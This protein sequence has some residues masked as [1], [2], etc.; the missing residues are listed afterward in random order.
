MAELL[1]ASLEMGPVSLN[2]RD[3]APL[4]DFYQTVIG[5][6]VLK[7]DGTSVSFGHSGK[8]IVNLHQT[9]KLQ[10]A[11]RGSAGLYHLAIRFSARGD[12]ARA[13]QRV[14]TQTSS[15]YTGSGD[16][17]VSEAFYLADPE[18]NGIELYY[19]R[20]PSKWTWKDGMVQME[21]LY[22]N[23]DQY[24]AKNAAARPDQTDSFGQ[25]EEQGTVQM[26]HVHLRVGDIELARR[27]YVD[28]LGFEITGQLPSAL[29][30]SVNKY[31]HHIGMN[32][33]ESRGVAK[34]GET[35]GLRNFA[36]ILPTKDD[37]QRLKRR[38]R[39]AKVEYEETNSTSSGQ[40]EERMAF[41]DGW[42]NKIVV[43]T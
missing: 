15:L 10:P 34:R 17:L 37:L 35:L 14:R 36:I 4:K 18:G 25:A 41:E 16:H 26:G 13:V 27:F 32:T 29:F 8:P 5:L 11:E 1:A 3:L 6:E 23:P 33:W 12:L 19:D 42:G 40:A 9:P 21:A 39:G 24:I 28:V 31:H 7:Q 22:I 38:L 30:V 20:D 2:V 43:R